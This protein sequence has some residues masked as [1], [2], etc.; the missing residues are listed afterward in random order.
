MPETFAV[1]EKCQPAA[2]RSSAAW[3]TSPALPGQLTWHLLFGL[4][5][6][7]RPAM[8]HPPLDH[9]TVLWYTNDLDID[10]WTGLN[11]SLSWM[12]QY[13]AS[14]GLVAKC[15]KS[16][17]MA[18]CRQKSCGIKKIWMI[19]WLTCGSRNGRWLI[20]SGFQHYLEPCQCCRI[21]WVPLIGLG[22]DAF[23][24]DM[25]RSSHVWKPSSFAGC[26]NR[27]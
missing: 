11:I 24:P 20:Q 21:C 13:I 19:S 2:G 15:L 3:I 26:L 5:K 1:R 7:Q 6:D 16:H 18:T 12:D 4:W 22:K 23:Q 17:V 10:P 14:D 9:V 25:L 8:T 27:W